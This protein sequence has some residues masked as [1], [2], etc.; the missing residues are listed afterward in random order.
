MPISPDLRKVHDSGSEIRFEHPH[1]RGW[2]GFVIGVALIAVA[3]VTLEGGGR[4]VLVALGALFAYG[5]LASALHRMELVLDLSR[6]RY[7][8]RQGRVG[9]V[10]SGEGGFE[11][12]EAV[13]L[14]KE[15]ERRGSDRVDEWEVEL[16]VKGWPRPVEVLETKDEDTA[17]EEARR[18]ARRLDA[19]L[20]ERT[21]T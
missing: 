12:I 10:E 15:L 5:G 20:R 4:W 11:D 17:R 16:V 9:A 8:W 3:F 6:R 1:A 2:P 19:E 7:R 14:V 18:L 13:V 21:T